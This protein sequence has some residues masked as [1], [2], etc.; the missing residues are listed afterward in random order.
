MSSYLF[1]AHQPLV[2]RFVLLF[3]WSKR[4]TLENGWVGQYK[5][6][7]GERY[8]IRLVKHIPAGSGQDLPDRVIPERP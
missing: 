3:C 5:E 8:F 4:V 6:F 2:F 7:R 1:A